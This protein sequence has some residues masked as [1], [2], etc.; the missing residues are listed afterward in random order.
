MGSRLTFAFASVLAVAAC[1]SPT[2]DATGASERAPEHRVGTAPKP[3]HNP[4]EL[5]WVRWQRDFAAATAVAKQS[6][7]PLFVLFQEVPGCST[8]VGFGESVL[9]HP[10]VIEAIETEFV[11]VA[12][13]NNKAGED[14]EVLERFGEPSW[15]NPVVRFVDHR[16]RD[17]IPRADGVWSTHGIAH[18]M[19]LALKAAGRPAP[20]YLAWAVKETS[21]FDRATFAMH[22]Y[23]SG[24]ACLG[25]IPGV[26]KTRAGWLGG[27][28]VVEV[29]FDA[30]VLTEAKLRQL[31]TNRGC[32]ELV[33]NAKHARDAGDSDQKYHL[34]RSKLR[35]LPLTPLQA[36]R[37]NAALGAGRS[38]LP[39]LSPRQRV[40]H[41]LLLR[42]GTAK[43]AGLSR[44]N[45]VHELA[46]YENELR[47]RLAGR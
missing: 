36:A 27:R 38:P 13:H 42:A 15:N 14:R 43:L 33:A 12:I 24:E 31:A 44:P 7:K 16:G 6:G 3:P 21:S 47:Q 19:T 20:D 35:Y 30:Q 17:L 22:C 23:W 8:C 46:S 5:G 11:P 18:R 29:D 40:L 39:W 32:G 37:V 41:D 28:E 45:A 25:D 2:V 34:K 9:S 10:L 4:K 26:L 1:K